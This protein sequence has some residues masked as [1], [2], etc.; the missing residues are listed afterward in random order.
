[1]IPGEFCDGEFCPIYYWEYDSVQIQYPDAGGA[2]WTTLR[3]AQR[4]FVL[5]GRENEKYDLDFFHI[6]TQGYNRD[7]NWEPLPPLGRTL[8][9]IERAMCR[10][11]GYRTICVSHERCEI[12][13]WEY[14]PQQ[15]H[16][17]D[18]RGPNV[19][20][21]RESQANFR[22]FGAK[23]EEFVGHLRAPSEQD[24][25]DASY[26]PL[27]APSTAVPNRRQKMYDVMYAKPRIEPIPSPCACCGY[28]MDSICI[29]C[30]WTFSP[31]QE[32]PDDPIGPN[33]I[34]LREAQKNFAAFGAITPERAEYA[35]RPTAEDQL[36]PDWKPL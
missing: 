19:F 23:D 28:L 24:I 36:A 1:M 6:Y 9:Y 30:R 32:R 17:D 22:Q 31:Q 11:C 13:G 5:L 4:N 15:T 14:S 8:P 33:F 20:T 27:A 26:V 7:P 21:L 10:C 25:R 12:C 16:P 2:N 3:E 29:F 18:P 35:R 34:S